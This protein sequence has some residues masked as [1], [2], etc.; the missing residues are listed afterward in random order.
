MNLNKYD[1]QKPPE[2]LP[3]PQPP[4]Q[5][6]KESDAVILL[7]EYLRINKD[8]GIT[9]RQCAEEQP[10][11]CFIPG[12]KKKEIDP[13]RWA[14]AENAAQLFLDA[15]DDL[16]ELITRGKLTV[17]ISSRVLPRSSVIHG[18]RDHDI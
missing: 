6:W 15:A 16:Q 12:L 14:I 10:C 3:L 11:L 4:L 8:Q 1:I 13:T 7:S 2:P 5:D 9:L 17:P 18:Y